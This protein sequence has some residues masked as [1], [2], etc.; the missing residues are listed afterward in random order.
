MRVAITG[1][2]LTTAAGAT[3]DE[4]WEAFCAA[5]TGIGENTIV[6]R[7]GVMSDRAGQVRTL[8]EPAEPR[9][10]RAI[11]LGERALAEALERAGLADGGDC[12][13][14]RRGFSLGT[15]LGGAR[16]GEKFHRDWLQQGYDAT[17]R[18]DLVEYPL[19]ATAD[20]LAGRFGLHGPRT[21]HSNA[22]AA[23]AVAVANGYEYLADGLADVVVAGGVD[24][25]AWLSFGGF[26]SL[27]VLS[28][29][30][31]AP[32]TRSEGITLGEGA[33]FVVLE[34]LERALERG[35][36]VHAELL[37]YGLTADAYHPT[38]PDPRGRGAL[39]AMDLALGM[40]GIDRSRIDYVNG[41][42]TGTPANDTGEMKTV[43]V[44]GDGR[45]PMSSTKSMTGHTL[46]AAGAVEAVVSVMTL[47]HQRLHPT[48][49]P[50]DDEARTAL[51]AVQE[52]GEVDIVADEARDAE[53]A[54]VLSNSFAFGGNNASLVFGAHRAGERPAS[55]PVAA[56]LPAEAVE[57]VGIAAL[58]G[59]AADADELRAAFAQGEPLVRDELEFAPGRI[60][61]IGRADDKALSRGL[62]PRALRRLD[63]LSTLAVQAVHQAIAEVGI[64]KTEL[65]DTGLVFATS[66][67]PLS[68]VEEFQ[69]GLIVD[70]EGDSKLFPNTVM[71]AAGGHIAMTFGMRGPTATICAGAT[72]GVSALHLGRQLVR[73]GACR[74]VIVVAADE[75]NAA[76]LA[77]YGGFPGYLATGP[78]APN[79]GSGVAFSEA[80]VAVVLEAR[81]EDAAAPAD[82]DGAAARLVRVAGMGL[83]GDG[84][85]A[86]RMGRTATAWR[87]SF[88]QALE[89]AGIGA[90]R[91]DAVVTAACG[92][93]PID[94]LERAA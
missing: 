12:P 3:A 7:E 1:Y 82:E 57:V 84:P 24:P 35:A 30:N 54:T 21:V 79:R 19:H 67:G 46:G 47:E 76:L 60:H 52:A 70:G 40:A 80:A 15:S 65:A 36:V 38:A 73:N 13:P 62:N 4:C 33:G 5:R 22:C 74:R 29:M 86:G 87:R 2:G 58:A 34:P 8:D 75:A 28:L 23:G 18:F 26:S 43:R 66:T 77:G 56:P 69:R 63:R 44:L 48:F 71:N 85:G 49:V 51:A 16:A 20:A 50:A 25:L 91:I 89:R 37:G 78:V 14:E 6:P 45:V 53:V 55:E 81:D 42:G 31:C 83:T 68:T 88:E 94:R 17:N 61:P 90:E 9:R 41:H 10:D 92:H 93:E 27:G 32:Y 39:K 72:S 64:S 59:A 11:R